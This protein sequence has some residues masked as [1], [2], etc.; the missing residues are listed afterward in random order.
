[1]KNKFSTQL[2]KFE[3][4]G[5]VETD[6]ETTDFAERANVSPRPFLS[7]KMKLRDSKPLSPKRSGPPVGSKVQGVLVERLVKANSSGFSPEQLSQYRNFVAKL[8]E[9]SMSGHSL[10]AKDMAHME[11]TARKAAESI[12]GVVSTL[13]K[14]DPVLRSAASVS[15]AAGSKTERAGSISS[16]R[17]GD[18]SHAATKAAVTFSSS[19]FGDV[20]AKMAGSGGKGYQ[21]SQEELDAAAKLALQRTA[22]TVGTKLDV[23]PEPRIFAARRKMEDLKKGF[24]HQVAE[25][26]VEKLRHTEVDAAF[27]MAQTEICKRAETVEERQKANTKQKALENALEVRRYLAEQV[28]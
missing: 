3:H 17:V 7:P 1:V 24:A 14:T 28:S 16:D 21:P 13:K 22:V 6:L 18:D 8:V 11:E 2:K 12:T 9:N 4:T 19:T 23:L 20:S 26:Q 5:F 27:A 15:S 25:R 10:T